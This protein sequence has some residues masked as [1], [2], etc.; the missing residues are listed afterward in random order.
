MKSKDPGELGNKSK[1]DPGGMGIK[2]KKD[3]GGV[4]RDYDMP[5]GG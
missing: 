5:R 3:P 1:R 4:G 2:N